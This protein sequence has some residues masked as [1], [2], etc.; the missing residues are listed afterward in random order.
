MRNVGNPLCSSLNG[1]SKQFRCSLAW[2]E[3]SSLQASPAPAYPL[4]RSITM[5]AHGHARQCS[6][7]TRTHVCGVPIVWLTDSDTADPVLSTSDRWHAPRQ[8]GRGLWVLFRQRHCHGNLGT[9]QGECT[10]SHARWRSFSNDA[11]MN[12]PGNN[13][14]RPCFKR[15]LVEGVQLISQDDRNTY[16]MSP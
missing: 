14:T 7:A 3:L 16:S 12:G 8:E 11:K 4:C 9:A 15:W 10:E 5:R 6:N 1:N 2:L 13:G